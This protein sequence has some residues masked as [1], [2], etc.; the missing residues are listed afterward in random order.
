MEILGKVLLSVKYEIYDVIIKKGICV[1]V[2]VLRQSF[3][4]VFKLT[5]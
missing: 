1:C 4:Y 3:M 5:Y 2:V